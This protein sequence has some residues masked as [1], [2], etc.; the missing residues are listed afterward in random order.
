MTIGLTN[1]SRYAYHQGEISITESYEVGGIMAFALVTD[2]N[3]NFENP[4]IV[5]KREMDISDSEDKILKMYVRRM[6]QSNIAQTIEEIY[7][8]DAS[9]DMIS[10]IPDKILSVIKEWQ[11]R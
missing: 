10:K 11:N 5:E 1:D 3:L 9:K 8:F 6:R 4:I 2:L 7:G